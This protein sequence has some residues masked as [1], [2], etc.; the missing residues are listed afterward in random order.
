M[1]TTDLEDGSNTSSYC[2]LCGIFFHRIPIHIDNNNKDKDNENNGGSSVGESTGMIWPTPWDDAFLNTAQDTPTNSPLTS[3][4]STI[5]TAP[6]PSSRNQHPTTAHSVMPHVLMYH[7]IEWDVLE[8]GID[9]EFYEQQDEM[10]GVLYERNPFLFPPLELFQ[11]EE[12]AVLCYAPTKSTTTSTTTPPTTSLIT[13]PDT[14]ITTI[15]SY[16]PPQSL[17]T[18]TTIH[19][20]IYYILSSRQ[21]NY[22]WFRSCRDKAIVF[23][24]PGNTWQTPHCLSVPNI[25]RVY[26][27]RYLLDCCGSGSSW[28][29]GG[30][31]NYLR[32]RIMIRDTWVEACSRVG[33]DWRRGV[34]C[35]DERLVDGDGDAGGFDDVEED[36]DMEELAPD[37]V[38]VTRLDV[39]LD[40]RY[41]V[42][43]LV[44]DVK[45]LEVA[46]RYNLVEGFKY[47][48]ESVLEVRSLDDVVE[49][50]LRRVY[51]VG[52][53]GIREVIERLVSSS[54]GRKDS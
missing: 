45:E 33:R 36:D 32:L 2:I 48:L 41:R 20:I 53:S 24:G 7:E 16:L 47:L 42:T 19:P 9:Y 8:Y 54:G 10:G 21:A 15:A 38:K 4:T 51:E 14:I 39:I 11:K 49:F 22:L 5:K 34:W 30:V 26:W 12:D 27:R 44:R 31:K 3:P 35:S 40:G 29:N 43:G 28:W 46:A 1:E 25:F 52:G 23:R 13:I 18:F 6:G 50:L 17:C 37:Q